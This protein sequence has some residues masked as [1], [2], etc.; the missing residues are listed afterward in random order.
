MR[1][2]FTT[3]A[4]T[5]ALTMSLTVLPATAASAQD[6]RQYNN[7]QQRQNSTQTQ[8]PDYSK[9]K[10]YTVGNREGYQDYQSKTQRK[11]HNH[12]YRNDPDRKAHDYGYQQGLQGQRGYPSTTDRH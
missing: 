5:V 3:I 10:F 2:V 7:D 11:T 8:H 1:N 12:A 4:A 6:Q 9:N